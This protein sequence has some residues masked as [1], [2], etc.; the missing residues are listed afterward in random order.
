MSV[1]AKYE[2]KTPKPIMG[3]LN[4]C[5]LILKPTTEISYP[6]EVLPIFAPIIIPI[7]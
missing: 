5:R 6:V 2:M 3:K 7:D 4:V 1:G